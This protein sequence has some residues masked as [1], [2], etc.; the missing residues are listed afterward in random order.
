[1]PDVKQ[2]V[3]TNVL[4]LQGK[5]LAEQATDGRL[6]ALA[7]L[8]YRVRPQDE[9]LMQPSTMLQLF[10]E[11]F[12]SPVREWCRANSQRVRECFLS[13]YEDGPAVFVVGRT[14]GYDYSLSGPLSDFEMELHRK[15]FPCSVLQLPSCNPALFRAFIDEKKAIQV[16][17]E[18]NTNT[19]HA[20]S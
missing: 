7:R 5:T 18:P 11:E 1:M 2:V 8:A 13:I 17:P 14:D 20:H 16:C 10:M 19:S 15:G 3:P 12:V 6:V 9:L 4:P